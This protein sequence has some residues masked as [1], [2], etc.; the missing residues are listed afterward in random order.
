MP[1]RTPDAPASERRLVESIKRGDEDA[2]V[3]LVDRYHASM[4]R[5]AR[6]FVP[7]R[8]VAEDVVQETWLAVI[9][10]IDR[11]EGR[12]SLKTWLFRI[13]TN[14]AKTRGEREGR[15]VPFSSAWRDELESG[16]PAVDPTRF[17][18]DGSANAGG[19]TSLPAAIPATPDEQLL[20][21]ELGKIVEAA[22]RK[23]PPSQREVITLRDVDGLAADEVCALLD[24][25]ESNQ[26]V[27]LHRARSKV[28]VAVERYLEDAR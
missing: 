18:P 10:G 19:W 9:Q 6:V 1:P 23:L 25:T 22:M 15:V 21:H 5:L 26:R 27:L 16:E 14:R 13:L 8:A 17:H 20:T 2:F 11:F 28:R 3:D 12:S 24:I 7:S 4:V